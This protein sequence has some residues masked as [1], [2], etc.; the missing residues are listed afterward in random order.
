MAGKLGVN[1]L[2]ALLNQTVEELARNISIYHRALQ[3]HGYDPATR[4]VTVM[5]HTFL[6]ESHERALQMVREPLRNYFRSHTNLRRAALL[7]YLNLLK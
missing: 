6:D 5:L 7:C 4:T 3:E 2:T 1:I